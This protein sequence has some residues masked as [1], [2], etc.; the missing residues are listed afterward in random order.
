MAFLGDLLIRMKVNTGDFVGD[1]SIEAIMA[2]AIKGGA[3]D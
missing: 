2:E 1:Y 3:L